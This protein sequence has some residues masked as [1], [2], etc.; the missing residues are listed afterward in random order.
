MEIEIVRKSIRNFL[1]NKPRNTAAIS[2][3]LSQMN[4]SLNLDLAKFLEAD[5]FIVRI[6]EVR[7]SGVIDPSYSLSEHHGRKSEI[8]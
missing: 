5:E 1:N 7:N 3:W 6:G 4:I 8:N 2:S